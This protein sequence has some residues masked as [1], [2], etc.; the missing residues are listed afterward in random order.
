MAG[1]E[2]FGKQ[3][4]KFGDNKCKFLPS[5]SGFSEPE[6]ASFSEINHSKIKIIHE[7]IE[8]INPEHFFRG[9]SVAYSSGD[10][11]LI[12]LKHLLI[13]LDSN[14][15]VENVVI[16]PVLVK[17][18]TLEETELVPKFIADINEENNTHILIEGG[19]QRG[20]DIIIDSFGH[21]FTKKWKKI[22]T[23]NNRVYKCRRETN[24]SEC[25]AVLYVNR[26]LE[27]GEIGDYYKYEHN[28]ESDYKSSEIIQFIADLKR[29]ALLDDHSSGYVIKNVL[30][31][32]NIL[33]INY[34]NSF[35]G[36]PSLRALQ[37][38]VRRH[39]MKHEPPQIKDLN[40]DINSEQFSRHVPSS[41]LRGDVVNGE[42]GRHLIFASDVQLELLKKARIWYMDGTFR[43]VGRPFVQLFCIHVVLN[44]DFSHQQIPVLF[45]LMSRLRKSDYMLVFKH[46]ISVI[47]EQ[48]TKT[49]CVEKVMIDF[50]IALWSAIR[51]LRSELIFPPYLIVKGCFFHFVQ[52]VFR[53]IT[54]FGLKIQYLQDHDTRMI[55]GH[56]MNLPL[57]PVQFI[58][59]EYERLENV[60]TKSGI[61]GLIKLATY[62][63]QNWIYGRN[64]TVVDWEQYREFNRTNNPCEGFHSSLHTRISTKNNSLFLLCKNLY[65][66]ALN[67]PITLAIFQNSE[68]KRRKPRVV[69]LDEYISELWE[70]LAKNRISPNIF[71]TAVTKAKIIKENKDFVLHLSRIDLCEDIDYVE[72]V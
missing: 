56:F 5:F 50:E 38:I 64:W 37:Q 4:R 15:N 17:P 32:S 7:E 19:S 60:C 35:M 67:V 41:F 14:E 29:E 26:K 49:I 40:F 44:N 72:N 13:K 59:P 65:H 43:V 10:A 1:K 12:Y 52:A 11:N 63:R 28:H 62:F 25:Q 57:L 46:I 42:D 27:N 31:N 30:R 20:S 18:D 2:K 48:N 39:R 24:G 51:Q 69:F 22:D 70:K 66:E 23:E 58:T 53:K 8:E 3:K 61:E 68:P 9:F 47:T 33:S 21:Q 54:Q 45:V 71:L 6:I 55:C 34:C 36:R 16:E